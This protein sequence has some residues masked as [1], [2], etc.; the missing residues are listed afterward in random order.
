MTRLRERGWKGLKL[1][2]ACLQLFYKSLRHVIETVF[3]NDIQGLLFCVLLLVICGCANVFSSTFVEAIQS[4]HSVYG[5]AVKY[6]AFVLV[7]GVIGRWIYLHY[8]YTQLRSSKII[9][10]IC[11]TIL[12]LFIAVAVLGLD[13]NGA[14]RW[15]S[16]GSVSLQPSEFAKLAG[17]LF[18]AGALA[19]SPWTDQRK[20]ELLGRLIPW[21][22]DAQQCIVSYGRAIWHVLLYALRMVLWPLIFA[23]IT[24]LQPDMGTASLIFAFSFTLVFL[25]GFPWKW[26]ANAAVCIGLPTLVLLIIFAPYRLARITNF[27]DP[28]AH[29]KEGGYQA[30]QSILAVGSGGITGTGFTEGSAKFFYLPEAHTDFAF[31]VWSQEWGFIGFLFVLLCFIGLGYFA[32]RI[33]RSCRE[34]FGKFLATGATLVILGQAFFNMWMVSGMLPVTGVPLPFISYGGSAVFTN[35]MAITFI[36]MVGKATLHRKRREEAIAKLSPDYEYAKRHVKS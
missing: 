32:L 26:I 4:G 5:M 7:S 12:L 17:V 23:G 21:N 10:P 29:A 20:K 9:A 33:A 16:V 31:A 1:M 28:W 18:T 19:S 14:R 25:N 36:C 35:L 24:I 22:V 27:V 8:D 6:A 34:P 30:V 15:L 13:I 2:W 11:V 3:K